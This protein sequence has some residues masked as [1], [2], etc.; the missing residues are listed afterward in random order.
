MIPFPYNV[1]R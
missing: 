1:E